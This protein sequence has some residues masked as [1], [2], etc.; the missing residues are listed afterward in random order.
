[1]T[2]YIKPREKGHN[3][4]SNVNSYNLV[5]ECESEKFVSLTLWQILS[6]IYCQNK[7]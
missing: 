6:F 5:T 1:M 3:M 4:K 7:T 2:T